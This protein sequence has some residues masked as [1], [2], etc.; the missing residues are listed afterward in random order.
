MLKPLKKRGAFLKLL[1]TAVLLGSFAAQ[2]FFYETSNAR[3][4]E[5]LSAMR[6]RQM[7][8]KSALM[9]E[10]MYFSALNS[11]GKLGGVSASELAAIKASLAAGKVVQSFSVAVNASRALPPDEISRPI[12]NAFADAR[13]V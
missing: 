13:K 5:L 6:D 8:D 10:V 2:N 7:I 1:G 12:K 11:E 9:Q 3:S 4:A